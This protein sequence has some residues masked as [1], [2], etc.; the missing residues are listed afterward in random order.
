[1]TYDR[2]GEV[3]LTKDPGGI[4]TPGA[5]FN[6]ADLVLGVQ[7]ESWAPGTEFR[8]PDGHTAKMYGAV[9]VRSDGCRLKPGG[10]GAYKWK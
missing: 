5:Q 6:V 7:F 3:V 1:M 8:L 10:G 9:L 4:F 2:R